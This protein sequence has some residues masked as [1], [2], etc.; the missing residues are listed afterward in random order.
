MSPI[1]HV[2]PIP[3]AID[4]KNRCK[5]SLSSGFVP[6]PDKRVHHRR[7]REGETNIRAFCPRGQNPTLKRRPILIFAM[8][9]DLF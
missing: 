1:V 5:A 2:D 7:D 4:G 8:V 6:L 9:P 3:F